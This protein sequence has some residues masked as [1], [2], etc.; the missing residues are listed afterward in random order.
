LLQRAPHSIQELKQKLYFE[1][2]ALRPI[3][4]KL[5]QD[6]MIFETDNHQYVWNHE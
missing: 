4:H 3:L 2:E 5:L 6:Q 1:P